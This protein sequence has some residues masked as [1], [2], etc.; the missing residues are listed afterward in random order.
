MGTRRWRRRTSSSSSTR[1]PT[2]VSPRGWPTISR[3]STPSSRSSTASLRR[4]R[5]WSRC[6]RHARCSAGGSCRCRDCPARHRGPA[7]GPL[8][9]IPSPHADGTAKPYN[10]AVVVRHELTHAF[11]LTQT[12]FLVPIWLT[13]G[14][15]VRAEG[16]RRFDADRDTP[17]RPARGRHRLQPRHHRPRL[18]QLRQSPGRDARV[19]P[20]FP[21]RELHREH[22][23]RGGDREVA[24][25]VQ[26]RARCQRRDPSSVR[27]RARSALEKGYREYLR[28]LVKG[29]P[30]AEK[31]MT[32]AELETA[33]KK[34][35][36]DADIAA[37]L[38]AEYARRGKPRRGAKARRCGAGEGEGAPGASLVKARLLQRDKDA[39]RRDRRCWRRPRR[40]TRRTSACLAALGR[41][42]VELKELASAVATFEAIR[43]RGGVGA[44]R[45]RNARA[46]PRGREGYRETR[47]R[48]GGTGC[49]SSGQPRRSPAASR[50]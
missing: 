47:G 45:A 34:N 13:E 32:F 41:L 16:T 28:A 36:D 19:P 10:W 3:N 48:A 46:A 8:I 37:R 14:L 27:G 15:A 5:S 23:R 44:G 21:V 40:R 11:N 50:G 35:P 1:R 6:W 29:A 20:G 18:P 39:G 24:R 30:R 22:A 33:H 38:A 17:A 49:P 42:Q 31:P 25:R 2:R 43:A 9:A 12:G 26:A 7:P 4:G